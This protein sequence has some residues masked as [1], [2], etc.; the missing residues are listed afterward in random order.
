MPTLSTVGLFLLAAL[1]LAVT[2]GPGLLYVRARSLRGGGRQ[3]L[4]RHMERRL[5]AAGMW[6][7][8][9]RGSRL[10]GNVGICVAG[11]PL[12]APFAGPIAQRLA[13]SAR[14][15]WPV[16]D[17]RWDAHGPGYITGAGR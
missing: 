5:V 17:L 6:L 11:D 13:T 1:V 15:A 12:V 16:C 2:P 10:A 3:G 9:H 4:H 8:R 7:Q 14:A